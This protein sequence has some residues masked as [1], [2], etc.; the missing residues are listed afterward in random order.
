MKRFPSYPTHWSGKPHLMTE[1]ILGS[2]N[3]TYQVWE[4]DRGELIHFVVGRPEVT[5]FTED[6]RPFQFSHAVHTIDFDGN[7]VEWPLIETLDRPLETKNYT[8][9]A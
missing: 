4:D 5:A 6:G 2:K 9:L 7:C 1:E 8:R 3:R